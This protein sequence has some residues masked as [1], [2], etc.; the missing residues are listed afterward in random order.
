M[1]EPAD[2]EQFCPVCVMTVLGQVSRDH[3]AEIKAAL[4]DG[5]PDRQHWIEPKITIGRELRYGMVLALAPLLPGTGML[6]VCWEHAGVLTEQPRVVAAAPA[7][8]LIRPN[9][10]PGDWA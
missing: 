4:G 9:L 7:P 6:L 2:G 5:K 8:G 10:W 3:D 1:P